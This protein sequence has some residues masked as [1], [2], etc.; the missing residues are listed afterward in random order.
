MNSLKSAVFVEWN[1]ANSLHGKPQGL[2]QKFFAGQTVISPFNHSDV[3][4]VAWTKSLIKMNDFLFF[5]FKSDEF[6]Y[7]LRHIDTSLPTEVQ[8]PMTDSQNKKNREIISG[9]IYQ[10]LVNSWTA[11]FGIQILIHIS[12]LWNYRRLCMG[13]GIR[14][15]YSARVMK[16]NSMWY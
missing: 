4:K 3:L 16:F 1:K 9:Q 8:T 2:L 12:K 14:L 5:F 13:S 6:V 11:L 7:W 10:A 15:V